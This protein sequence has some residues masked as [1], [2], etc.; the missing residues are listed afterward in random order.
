MAIQNLLRLQKGQKGI[1]SSVDTQILP[2]K[3]YEI[4]LLPGTEVQLKFT[5]PFHDP[6]CI[7]FG[8]DNTKIALRK[9]EAQH[10]M[11]EL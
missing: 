4:G 6:I 8:K 5:G 3:L 9:S 2:S 10:I 7:A 1:I 11:I